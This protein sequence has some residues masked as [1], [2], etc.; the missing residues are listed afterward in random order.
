MAEHDAGL[1]DF[2]VQKVKRI[3]RPLPAGHPARRAL[4][5][6]RSIVEIAHCVQGMRPDVLRPLLD[7]NVQHRRR[8]LSGRQPHHRDSI[9]LTTR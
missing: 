9:H 7:L 5:E 6:G 2:E 3:L 8:L 1:D 4:S